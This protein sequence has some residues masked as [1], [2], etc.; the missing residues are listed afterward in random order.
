MTRLDEGE[1]LVL[2]R[3]LEDNIRA[4]ESR[5]SRI[6]RSN[7]VGSRT[8]LSSRRW[9]AEQGDQPIRTSTAL[10]RKFR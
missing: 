10:A 6:A 7:S 4:G 1:V 9:G 3:M 8:Y 5:S 2:E